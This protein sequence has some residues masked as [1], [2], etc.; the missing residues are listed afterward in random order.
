MDLS[1]SS[2]TQSRLRRELLAALSSMVSGS[3]EETPSIGEPSDIPHPAPITPTA[4]PRP[5]RRR[6]SSC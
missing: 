3:A 6:R 4:G 1:M 5:F 2:K